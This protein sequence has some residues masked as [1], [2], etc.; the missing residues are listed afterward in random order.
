ME[1]FGKSWMLLEVVRTLLSFLG[2]LE[3]LGRFLKVS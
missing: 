2:L 3:G 1:G